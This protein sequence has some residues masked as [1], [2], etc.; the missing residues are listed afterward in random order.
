MLNHFFNFSLRPLLLPV[1]TDLPGIPGIG[2]AF[3][4]TSNQDKVPNEDE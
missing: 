4:T 3:T 2:S 1:L